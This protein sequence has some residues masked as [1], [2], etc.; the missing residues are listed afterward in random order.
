[1]SPIPNQASLHPGSAPTRSS[2]SGLLGCGLSWF[3]LLAVLTVSVAVFLFWNGPLWLAP[4]GASHLGRIVISYLAVIPL[5]GLLLLLG[6]RWSWVHL[7][8]ATAL[9]WAGKLIV[10]SSLYSYLATGSVQKYSPAPVADEEGSA[11]RSRPARAAP[12]TGSSEVAGVVLDRGIPIAGVVVVAGA[13]G[14]SFRDAQRVVLTISRAHYD[15]SVYLATVRD[16]VRVE[17]GDGVLH[18]VRAHRERRT[19]WNV[20][21]PPGVQA[22]ALPTAEAGIYELSCDEH[23]AERATLVVVDQAPAQITDGAGRFFLR[24]LPAGKTHLELFRDSAM[25]RHAEVVTADGARADVSF[26]LTELD[27]KR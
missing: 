25:P 22:L 7:A 20:P 21:S 2:G 4:P 27:S 3:A 1:M 17:N 26:E 12:S 19:L 18:N 9:L 6:K 13:Q 5:C 10:T 15:R 16:Q 23:P 14:G 8:S 24:G 11:V